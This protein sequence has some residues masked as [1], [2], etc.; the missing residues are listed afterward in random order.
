MYLKVC[1]NLLASVAF[2]SNFFFAA[3]SCGA[4]DKKIGGLWYILGRVVAPAPER[5]N[6]HKIEGR[7]YRLFFYDEWAR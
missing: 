3:H 7:G 1:D 4:S 2:T 5:F 6:N